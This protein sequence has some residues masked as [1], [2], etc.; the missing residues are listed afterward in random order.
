MR[1]EHIGLVHYT[2]LSVGK[3][4]GH[5]SPHMVKV[6]ALCWN[7][8]LIHLLAVCIVKRPAIG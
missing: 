3:C 7:T 2:D 5:V 1:W 6:N 8:A 4:V